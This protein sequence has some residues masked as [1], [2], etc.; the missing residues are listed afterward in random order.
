MK[1]L[2]ACLSNLFMCNVLWAFALCALI[3]TGARSAAAQQTIFNVPAATTVE[4]GQVKLEFTSMFRPYDTNAYSV[5]I[6]RLS[7]GVAAGAELSV[8]AVSTVGNAFGNTDT[9]L[10]GGKW[11]AYNNE[12]SGTAI[13]LSTQLNVPI[14]VDN[15]SR[16]NRFAHNLTI[17]P[18]NSVRTMAPEQA[19]ALIFAGIHQQMPLFGTRLSGG[20]Y[21]GTPRSL[22]QENIAGH[23]VSVE[24]P[25]SNGV[26][27]VAEWISGEHRLGAFTPGVSIDFG[28]HN[29]RAGYAFSNTA[30][31][32]N[33]YVLRYG[34][35]F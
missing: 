17:Y 13:T 5:S 31:E 6:P 18:D 32:F 34:L 4:R 27:F 24:Q 11:R 3:L 12:E 10:L 1:R 21:N 15:S 33:G 25:L 35:K 29:I 2:L 28:K 16:F 30:R 19:S 23:W 8:G 26:N 7:V 14:N 9:L 20:F 22:V